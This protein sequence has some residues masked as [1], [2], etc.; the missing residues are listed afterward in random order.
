LFHSTRSHHPPEDFNVNVVAENARAANLRPAQ[1]AAELDVG[2]ETVRRWIEDGVN[3]LDGSRLRLTAKRVGGRW[4]VAR[5]NLG[6]FLA[7]LQPE[8]AR[9]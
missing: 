2:K 6:A 5:A 1:I 4:R 9:G 8:P 7:A 3:A